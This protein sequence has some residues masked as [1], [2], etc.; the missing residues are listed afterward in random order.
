MQCDLRTNISDGKTSRHTKDD[1]TKTPQLERRLV[2][3]AAQVGSGYRSGDIFGVLATYVASGAIVADGVLVHG[4][5]LASDNHVA[6]AVNG[7]APDLGRAFPNQLG[8]MTDA[9]EDIVGNVVLAE[10][11]HHCRELALVPTLRDTGSNVERIPGNSEQVLAL[12][13]TLRNV[14][15]KGTLLGSDASIGFTV[16]VPGQRLSIMIGTSGV[17]VV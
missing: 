15:L 17:V 4:R 16:G 2:R 9:V 10:V 1:T 13:S 14:V 11:W 5:R 12:T 8:E 3:P 7:N 6:A